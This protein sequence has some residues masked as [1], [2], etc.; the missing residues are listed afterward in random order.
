M[1]PTPGHHRINDE[2]LD[3]ETR[4]I[5][6]GGAVDLYSAPAFKE[7]LARALE[8]GTRRI[9]IDLSE[10]TFIDSTALGVIAGGLRRLSTTGGSLA[11]VCSHPG[12]M[13]V[14]RVSGFDRFYPVCGSRAEAL[15][16]LTN[17]PSG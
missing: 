17:E 15:V 2:E 6:V 13:R 8:T 5:S 10:A 3:G 11:I 16:A 12:P 1:D 4:L 14:F 7:A 9:V